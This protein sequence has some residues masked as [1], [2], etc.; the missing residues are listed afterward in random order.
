M[1]FSWQIQKRVCAPM[2][3]TAYVVVVAV[4]GG[5]VGGGGG[6]GVAEHSGG[7]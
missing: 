4:G 5:G 1:R 3:Q 2:L 7:H 6:G